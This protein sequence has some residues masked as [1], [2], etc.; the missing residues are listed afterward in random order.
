MHTVFFKSYILYTVQVEIFSKDLILAYLATLFSLL[1][2][3]IA[4][5]TSYLGVMYNII[6]KHRKNY[7]SLKFYTQI[8]G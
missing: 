2:L 6:N 5:N 3:Y 8:S 1:K 4:N 7:F